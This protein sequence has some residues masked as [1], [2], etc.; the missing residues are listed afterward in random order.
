MIYN[1]SD[2][3]TSQTSF[4]LSS[5]LGFFIFY[6][7]SDIS[8]FSCAV[9]CPISSAELSSPLNVSSHAVSR[10]IGPSTPGRQPEYVA[11]TVIEPE[12]TFMGMME[13]YCPSLPNLPVK[14][15]SPYSYLRLP[16]IV[17]PPPKVLLSSSFQIT[18]NSIG[19]NQTHASFTSLV[20]VIHPNPSRRHGYVVPV[21]LE[22]VTIPSYYSSPM[23]VYVVGT[24][25]LVST[26]S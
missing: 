23:V 15:P 18:A 4:S 1:F 26:K 16:D 14:T 21:P 2:S 10:C 22:L 7:L 12:Y 17:L 13:P 6:R 19:E 20:D 24:K 8:P 5:I 9:S 25:F 11:G 3:T